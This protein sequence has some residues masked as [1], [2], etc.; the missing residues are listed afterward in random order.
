VLLAIFIY[1][2]WDSGV[3]VNEETKDSSTAPGRAAIISTIILVGIY[4]VVT[5]AAQAYGGTQNLIDNAND[6][7]A[8]IGHSVFGSPFDKI[9]IIA[10]LTSASASTQTTILPTARTSLSMA[11]ARA[12]PGAFG[13][14]HPR[15]LSPSVST[16][17]MGGVSI[18]VYVGLTLISS[19]IIVDCVSALGLMIAFYYG[20]TGFA[21]VIFYRRELF[22]SVKNFLFVGVLPTLGG[23]MLG[24][25]FVK[26]SIDLSKKGAGSGVVLGLGSP[27]VIGIGGLLLGAVLMLIWR[28][29]NPEFFRRKTEVAHPALLDAT[30]AGGG[31]A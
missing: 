12:L 27:F 31:G 6:V 23:L 25:A 9:L 4:V 19:N 7:F 5:T 28:G 26:S 16:L 10:V 1:W 17:A 11:R 24:Y 30:P 15:Y 29:L 22:R 13:K 8:N 21:C 3:T 14:I 20:I 18:V 2:G